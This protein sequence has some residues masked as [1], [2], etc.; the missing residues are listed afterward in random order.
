MRAWIMRHRFWLAFLSVALQGV[1]L[2]ARADTVA[3]AAIDAASFR[4]SIS[5]YV[6]YPYPGAFTDVFGTVTWHSD[7]NS[8]A[9]EVVKRI[10]ERWGYSN[11]NVESIEQKDTPSTDPQQVG[12][13]NVINY[14]YQFK[15]GADMSFAWDDVYLKAAWSCPSGYVLYDSLNGNHPNETTVVASF[16]RD[17]TFHC[18]LPTRPAPNSQQLGRANHLQLA[19]M[20]PSAAGAPDDDYVGNPINAGTYNKYEVATDI[21]PIGRAGLRWERFY[22]SGVTVYSYSWTATPELAHLGSHWRGTYDSHIDPSQDYDPDTGQY[23]AAATLTRADGSTLYYRQ[24]NGQYVGGADNPHPL[25]AMAEGGWSYT[26]ENDVVSRYDMNGRLISQ[27]DRNG[28][29]LSLSYDEAGL[30]S[31]VADP[32]GRAL[33]FAYDSDAR[34]ISVTDPSGAVV[35]YEYDE[36]EESGPQADLAYVIYP[37][38][39]RRHY[40]YN[41]PAQINSSLYNHLLT[42]IEDESGQRYATFGY[43]S[44]QATS[45]EH[46]GGAGKV[47]L[48]TGLADETRVTGPLRDTQTYNYSTVLG[49]KRLTSHIPAH[50]PPPA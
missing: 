22:N 10:C 49:V 37:D 3:P 40:L 35:R 7:V 42:G 46:A 16:G 21:A 5:G 24:Q 26:D 15:P 33:I 4:P 43:W 20:C 12:L 36:S 38:G 47:T 39:H 14:S 27:A 6:A 48:S 2:S 19:G 44:G 17:Q 28:N 8:G 1:A 31:R 30:L 32:Q 23:E 13:L 45:S 50:G 34:L 11:C 29:L 25:T 41:E 9:R 18:A